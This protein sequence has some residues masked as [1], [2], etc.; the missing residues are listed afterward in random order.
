MNRPIHLLCASTLFIAC[1][2]GDS[3]PRN[4]TG[5]LDPRTGNDGGAGDEDGAGGHS[6][7]A[8]GGAEHAGTSGWAGSGA[9]AGGEAGDGAAGDVY[10]TAGS[11]GMTA[12][13]GGAGGAAPDLAPLVRVVSPAEV[14]RPDAGGLLVD[15]V[16]V[17]CEALAVDSA[18]PVDVMSV[19]VEL[20]DSAGD[21]LDSAPAEAA[22]EDG[23]YSVE[24]VVA[25][26][27][28]GP[29]AIQCT[30]STVGTDSFS[31]SD[32][33]HHFIDHG[34]LITPLFPR[35]GDALVARDTVMQFQIEGV[36][37]A[38]SD[39]G[40]AVSQ[41]MI[42]VNGV[43]LPLEPT[44]TEDVY[45]VVVPF[46][47]TAL[48][49]PM[50]VGTVPIAVH[51]WNSREPAPVSAILPYTF[52]LDGSGPTIDLGSPTPLS[53]VGGEVTLE[54]TIEDDFSGVDADTI[55]VL[56]NVTDPADA[57]RYS[58]SSPAW[59]NSGS[60][61]RYS[62]DSAAIKG[63]SVQMTVNIVVSDEAGNVSD[64][65][66][67]LYYMDNEAPYVS[68]DPPT[69]RD[70]TRRDEKPYCTQPF[71]PVG[72]AVSDADTIPLMRHFRAFVLDRT[73]TVA[74]QQIFYYALTDSSRVQ[75]Y[76][77]AD[78]SVPLL[79]DTKADGIC[80]AVNDAGMDLP[81]QRLMPITPKGD[82][83][84]TPTID[85]LDP[86]SEPS[87]DPIE[88]EGDAGLCYADGRGAS[89]SLCGGNSDMWRATAQYIGG[90]TLPAVYAIG[91][92][93]AGG[94]AACAGSQWDLDPYVSID[95]WV[96]LA[97]VAYDTVGNR[98]V[99][100]PLRACIDDPSIAGTPACA[101][102]S[103]PPPSCTDGC[104]LPA[105]LSAGERIVKLY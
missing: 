68:L 64:T 94:G 83:P 49:D 62:F 10:A 73:S 36:P 7:V 40:A 85:L 91:V 48:F 70:L 97:A 33:I 12:N 53:V 32:S 90:Q 72:A 38:D 42:E 98:G 41:A 21:V 87:I 4:D 20:L 30:A 54:F 78:P 19:T 102:G 65:A 79:V 5:E 34:P 43:E 89:G 24:L 51:A 1:G 50:P 60:T 92:S 29:I 105:E 67:A 86:T 22:E 80:D 31:G 61:Y 23:L 101:D 6:G 47:D 39:A 14:T 103:E 66:S 84:A 88:A 15:S 17:V 77:Q 76:L 46:E 69:V 93:D 63:S 58:T 96:C 95:G 56:I 11:A 9:G 37:L 75:L 13:D 55:R 2:G 18:A 28:S 81:Q 59:S 3:R 35:A 100:R 25:N 26:L 52:V 104:A 27:P 99:S 82:L 44:A 45:D 16:E 57:V 74:G 71:D 8:G